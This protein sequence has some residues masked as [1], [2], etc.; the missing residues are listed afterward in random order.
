MENK[1]YKLWEKTRT[2]STQDFEMPYGK[3]KGQRLT[4]IV[5]NNRSY[6]K[7]LLDNSGNNI[8]SRLKELLS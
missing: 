4:W 6:T 8:K 5:E 7:W 3:Y 2:V 1:Q